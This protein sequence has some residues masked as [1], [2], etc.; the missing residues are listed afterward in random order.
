MPG[1]RCRLTLRRANQAG[2][3]SVKTV[4]VGWTLIQLVDEGIRSKTGREI[5]GR[6]MGKYDELFHRDRTVCAGPAPVRHLD[7]QLTDGV[8]AEIRGRYPVGTPDK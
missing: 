2:D 7:L 4:Q 8:V 3:P 6:S 5:P 1:A